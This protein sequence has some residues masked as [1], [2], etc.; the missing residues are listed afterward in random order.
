MKI[1]SLQIRTGIKEKRKRDVGMGN[2]ANVAVIGTGVMGSAAVRA[3]AT[4]GLTVAVWNR[5]P[6][7]AEALTG[8]GVF[9]CGDVVEAVQSSPVVVLGLLNYDVSRQ[10][11]EPARQWLDGKIV[12][13]TASGVPSHVEPFAKWVKDA[14]GRYLEAAI[15]NYPQ[16]VGT[17][18]CFTVYS[19]SVDDYREI[20]LF[21][22]ALAGTSVHLSEDITYAK[23]YHV[24]SAA[25]YYAIVNGSLEC[26][27]IATAMGVPLAD[28]AKSVPMYAV[29]IQQTIDVAVELIERQN[30]KQDFKD[31]QAPLT[32]HLD[33]LRNLPA[34]AE[35]AGVSQ[36]FFPVLRDRVQRALDDGYCREHV[37]VIYEQFRAATAG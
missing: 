2:V 3:C 23:A 32:T 10:V 20:S 12:V 1:S 33:I 6:E 29:G 17:E 13:Q 11:L 19:G 9:Q 16:E 5:E 36:S 8:G 15:L 34:V 14:G 24:V 35:Q 26:L 30:Y 18:N 31:Q 21:T 37:A 7:R 25:F 22:A 28:F 4:A 27:A